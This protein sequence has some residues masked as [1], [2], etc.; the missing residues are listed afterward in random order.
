V[1][2]WLFAKGWSDGGTFVDA[3]PFYAQAAAEQTRCGPADS[4]ALLWQGLQRVERENQGA[5]NALICVEQ[6]PGA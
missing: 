4:T 5:A 2:A 1:S 3:E 6:L